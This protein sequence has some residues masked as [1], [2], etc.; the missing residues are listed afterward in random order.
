MGIRR[1]F[2]PLGVH[3]S[4][5]PYAPDEIIH[6]SLVPA[7]FETILPRGTYQAAFTGGGGGAPLYSGFAGG[8][9]GASGG[10][11]LL[12]FSLSSPA[13]VSCITGNGGLGKS[14]IAGGQAGKGEDIVLAIEEMGAWIAAGG[15]GPQQRCRR[16]QQ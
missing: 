8:G 7:I 9:G 10:S 11:L 1:K 3:H 12:E 13:A 16:R 14:G 5:S 2:A 15:N 6:E 4:P